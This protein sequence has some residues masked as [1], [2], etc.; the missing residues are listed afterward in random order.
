MQEVFLFLELIQ[1]PL[2]LL[3]NVKI[4]EVAKAEIQLISIFV[5]TLYIPD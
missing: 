4:S 3:K 5:Q 2:E 1:A